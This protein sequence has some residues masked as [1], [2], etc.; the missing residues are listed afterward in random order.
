[1]YLRAGF[2]DYGMVN[3]L[4]E[5]AVRIQNNLFKLEQLVHFI[6]KIIWKDDN[7]NIQS[8]EHILLTGAG[9]TKNFGGLLASEM[10][11]VIFNHNRVQAH[12]KIKELMRDDF[13]YESIYHS[14]M[15]D[16]YTLDEKEAIDEA[17]K[18]AYENIDTILREY[19]FGIPSPDELRNV[20]ELIWRFNETGN[21]SFIF[22]LNQDLFFERL[23]SNCELSIPGIKNNSEWFTPMFK[24]PLSP[25]DYCNLPKKDELN[26]I[27][28][29]ILS[30]GNFFLIKLH[31]SCNWISSDGTENIVIGK[32]K[33]EQI[34][35]EPL[36]T[37]YSEVF[38]KALSHYQRRLLII[39]Y[40][41]G[42]EHINR[43]IAESV[44][45]YRLKIY[46]ISPESMANFREKIIGQNKLGIDILDGISGYFLHN[47]MEIFP[48]DN[49]QTQQKINLFE[50]FFE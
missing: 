47:L 33:K 46:I 9:F 1:M 20:L 41:F 42:D 5:F 10:W 29:D 31:G 34:Q 49:T 8:S 25:S 28:P 2:S 21:K 43:I 36:L 23:C 22:T 17:V 3:H 26:R 48:E 27:K 15:E 40:S 37:Y 30:D 16:S 39:G 14:I 19:S 38:K 35:K 12:P 11:S 44:R 50:S 6:R 24:M 18:V 45:K 13:D 32:G 7:M 4:L